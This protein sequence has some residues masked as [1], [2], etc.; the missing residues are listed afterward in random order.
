M[1]KVF[2]YML[3][4]TTCFLF[5]PIV[6]RVSNLI[7]LWLDSL[8]INPSSKLK[9]YEE[10]NT[11]TQKESLIGSQVDED[12]YEEERACKNKIGF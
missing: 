1:K 7:C 4:L 6:E 8:C 10:E 11:Y 12:Y 3:G 2:I 9:R 5:I